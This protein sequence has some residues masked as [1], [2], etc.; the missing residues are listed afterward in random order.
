MLLKIKRTSKTNRSWAMTK[1]ERTIENALKLAILE[2]LVDKK[3]LTKEESERI[4]KK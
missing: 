1:T 3:K 2:M 4:Q